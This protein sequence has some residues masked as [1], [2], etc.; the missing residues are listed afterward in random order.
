MRS[1]KSLVAAG[2]ASLMSSVAFAADLP[3]AP[4]PMAYA[5]PAEDFGGWYLRGDIGFS[6]QHV[7]RLNKV[8]DANNTSSIQNLGFNT[9]GIFGLGVGYQVNNWFRTDVT[10]EYRGNSQ[11]FGTDTV[12]LPGGVGTHTYHATKSEWVVLANA[13]VDLG[14]WWCVTPFIGA[15]VGAS[16]NTIKSFTDFGATQAG[17]TIL[18]T[19]YGADASKWSFA[20]AVYAGLAYQVTPNF[21]VELAYRFLNLGDATTGPTNSFDGVTVVNGTPFQF[22]DLTS[23]DIKLGVRWMFGEPPPPPPLMRKG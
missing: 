21:T 17:A 7:D 10:G 1:V 19:T 20:W 13:Y 22:K 9:A 6:N 11:F 4:P 12:T 15:G 2:A 16:F 23:Q 5:P 14:T 18:A 8:L 3:I